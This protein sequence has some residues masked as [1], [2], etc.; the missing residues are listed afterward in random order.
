MTDTNIC[1]NFVGFRCSPPFIFY[2]QHQ[3]IFLLASKANVKAALRTYEQIDEDK[4]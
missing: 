4:K 2:A 3:D 1:Y